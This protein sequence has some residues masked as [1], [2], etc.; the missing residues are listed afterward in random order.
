MTAWLALWWLKL[1]A[2]GAVIGAFW[3]AVHTYNVKITTKAVLKAEAEMTAIYKPKF[4]GLTKQFNGL[5]KQA[6]DLRTQVITDRLNATSAAN[7]ALAQ[8]KLNASNKTALYRSEIAALKSV[9]SKR[10][11]DRAADLAV[12]DL[13]LRDATRPLAASDGSDQQGVRLSGYTNGLASLYS[14]CEKDLGVL[15]ETTAGALD[16]LASAEAAVRALSP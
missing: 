10:D 7:A 5:T 6:N 11:A 3:L 16:R 4:E 15:I 1:L 2:I 8:E 9:A 14:Q 13:R 12:F